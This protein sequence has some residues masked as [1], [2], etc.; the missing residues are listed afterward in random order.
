MSTPENWFK[1]GDHL[2][3][4]NQYGTPEFAEGLELLKKSAAAD[5]IE[6]QVTLGH[7]HTQVHLLPNAYQEA[8]RWYRIA[9]EREHPVAQDRL[10]DLYMLGRGVPQSDTQAFQ[11][12][13]RTAEQA[14]AMAQCNLAYMHT[15]GLGTK[16]DEVAATTL[17]LQAASQGESRA[18]FN[19]GLRYA[20]GLGAPQDRVLAG[21]WMSNAARLDYPTAKGELELLTARLT[22]AERIKVRELSAVIEA[23]FVALQQAL[24]RTPGA[25]ASIEAYRQIVEE[26]F[27]TLAVDGFST[28]AAKR[29]RQTEE[30]I[31]QDSG[32]HVPQSPVT[33]CNQP[34]IFTVDEFVS[35]TEAAHLMALAA[36]HMQSAREHTQDRLSQEHTAFTGHSAI[37]HS[38]SCDAVIR[39]L[40]RRIAAAFKLPMEQ[41]EPVSVLRY[42]TSDHYAPH[43]DYFDAARLE[44]NRRIG[45]HSGQRVAS[46]L[47]YLLA[48]EVGGETHYLKL[49]LK[50]AGRPRMALCHSNLTAAGTPDPMTLHTGEAVIKG[51]KWLA[52]TTLREKPLL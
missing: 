19:L 24:A 1:D 25:T 36:L 15:Q 22:Q 9:A 38:P 5:F 27:A 35:K 11:W 41:V 28:A 49:K 6:A 48:P 7:L 20:A 23:N 39:N 34:R 13:A 21:A 47:V 4:A 42:Q 40:E 17:Y 16:P 52:R 12:Y 31:L 43:V 2:V 45:D 50:I 29:L 46:F 14:Y 18:Y 44:Y 51:E 8:A 33:V 32:P 3:A 10:A 30:S 37:F 26:N